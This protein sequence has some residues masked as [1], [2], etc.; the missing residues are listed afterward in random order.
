VDVYSRQF[1][2]NNPGFKNHLQEV[3]ESL[4]EQLPEG[5][6]G[7]VVYADGQTLPFEDGKVDVLYLG[8]V[9]GGHVKDDELWGV[10]KSQTQIW[11][12]KMNL[13]KEAKRVL[14]T[15]GKLII[16]E[17]FPPVPSLI[18]T[19]D[20][21]IAYLEHEPDFD[22]RILENFKEGDQRLVLELTKRKNTETTT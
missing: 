6:R 13:I 18:A 3:K 5:V 7:E 9:I 1:N 8:N 17:D 12:E 15:E 14:K 20:K 21:L 2:P 11:K 10:D 22:T 16:E 4:D 19:W